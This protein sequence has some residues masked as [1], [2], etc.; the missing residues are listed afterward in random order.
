MKVLAATFALLLSG[1][2]AAQECKSCSE[3]D[4]CIQAYVKATTEAQRATK[5]A[6]RDWQQNLD[7]KTS[8]EFSSRGMAALQNVMVLQVRAEL[9]RLK[10]CLAKI[11]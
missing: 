7:K 8:A 1:P 10:E 2:A 5:V 9:D 4:A 11:K 6:I 3:A